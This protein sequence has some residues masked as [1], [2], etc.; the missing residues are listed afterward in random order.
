MRLQPIILNIMTKSDNRISK[1]IDTEK[2]KK[3]EAEV[4]AEADTNINRE[5]ERQ[6]LKKE[7]TDVEGSER[8]AFINSHNSGP[9]SPSPSDEEKMYAFFYEK[10]KNAEERESSSNQDE[11]SRAVSFQDSE[12]ASIPSEAAS[13]PRPYA[14]LGNQEGL[15][16]S[17]D[18]YEI[19]DEEEQAAATNSRPGQATTTVEVARNAPR[20][21]Q[22][23]RH[24]TRYDLTKSTK[25]IPAE[26]SPALRRRL[27]DF[28]FAQGKRKEKYG[29]K[30][31]WGIIGLYDFLSGIRTDVEW[32]ED[33]AWRREHNQ[34]YLSWSDFDEAKD[35]GFNQ[36]FFT[37]IVLFV[38]TCCL[39]LSIGVNG[40]KVEPFSV[41]PMIGPSAETLIKI[42]A[43]KTSLIVD[44]N[45]WYR[46]F[47]SHGT[48]CWRNPLYTQYGCNMVY[49]IRL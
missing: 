24:L 45:Q 41:N 44:E 23:M 46:L 9:R 25:K 17:E 43:K 27:R 1:E 13:Q 28:N 10:N 33:A 8:E 18:E 48:A 6:G 3:G 36:P 49:R 34:P 20:R 35:T 7:K 42:G 22:L 38:C 21:N 37:Y 29:E 47:F 40:W 31:M 12:P 2:I 26:I 5:A 11:Q 30:N 14:G 32:A 16:G 39:I 15:D 4:E 19:E